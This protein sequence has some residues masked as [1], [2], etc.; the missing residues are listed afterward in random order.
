M[1]NYSTMVDKPNMPF[2]GRRGSIPA[3]EYEP[4]TTAEEDLEEPTPFD[5]STLLKVDSEVPFS[6]VEYSIFVLLGVAMLWAWYVYPYRG[7]LRSW[8][9]K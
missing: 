9:T 2:G 6:W 5:E 1:P 8:L 3:H 7:L 4:L